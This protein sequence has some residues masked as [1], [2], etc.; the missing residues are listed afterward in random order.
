MKAAIVPWVQA[1]CSRC[2]WC[3]RDKRLL[4]ANQIAT[5]VQMQSSHAKYML[6]D[7]DATMLLPDAITRRVVLRTGNPNFCAG[8]MVWSGI[9]IADPKPHERIAVI[10]VGGPG[11]LTFTMEHSE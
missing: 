3:L 5:G 2:E 9:R 6:A 10:G 8:Y 11:Y 4:C 7:A 1:S